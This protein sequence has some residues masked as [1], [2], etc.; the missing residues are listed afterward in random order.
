MQRGAYDP[1]SKVIA[2]GNS[3]LW[4]REALEEVPTRAPC[5]LWLTATL[6]TGRVTLLKLF[7]I[8]AITKAARYRARSRTRTE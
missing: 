5:P 4:L 6:H 2:Q 8:P 3:G 7:L 1:C